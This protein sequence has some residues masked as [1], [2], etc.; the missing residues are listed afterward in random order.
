[1][2]TD[3]TVGV[4]TVVL[5]VGITR[6]TINRINVMENKFVTRRERE[7][8]LKAR[9]E[10]YSRIIKDIDAGSEKFA[11]I[12]KT[13][14]VHGELLSSINSKLELYRRFLSGKCTKSA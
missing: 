14:N 2:W 7:S 5:L 6:Y 9:D 4:V 1:M 12:Q 11:E 13:L 8:T 3:I 10:R